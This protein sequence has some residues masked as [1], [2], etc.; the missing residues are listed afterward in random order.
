[1]AILDQTAR[2]PKVKFEA[3]AV[4]KPVQLKESSPAEARPTPKMMGIR[5]SRAGRG[6]LSPRI[7]FA[8]TTLNAGSSVFT[9]WVREIATAANEMFAAMCPSACIDA[10]P[11]IDAN[12][13][14]EMTL[15]NEAPLKPRTY[16]N[17]QYTRPTT[18]CTVETVHGKGKY[19]KMDLL[20]RLKPMFRAYHRAMYPKVTAVGANLTPT[21]LE[22]ALSKGSSS[23]GAS[24]EAP[25]EAL[26]T[27]CLRETV[28]GTHRDAP[29]LQVA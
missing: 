18:T 15:S 21:I 24:A 4:R 10:G 20:S 5:D 1:M 8:S 7:S 2:K 27:T 25:D 16:M 22:T 14:F 13:F 26:T 19:L 23:L 9:V 29:V 11:K 3:M 6:V 12:S 17:T 28:L